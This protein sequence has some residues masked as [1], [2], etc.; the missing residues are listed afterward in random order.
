MWLPFGLLALFAGWRYYSAC[1]TVNRD[2]FDAA[3][4]RA[5]EAISAARNRILRRLGWEVTA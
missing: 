3:I 2:P 5:G 4:D 1:F